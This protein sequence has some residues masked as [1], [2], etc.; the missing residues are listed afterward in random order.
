MAH[1]G[2]VTADQLIAGS[3]VLSRPAEEFDNDPSVE[4]MWAMKAMEHAEVYFNILCSVDPKFL[5][6]TPHDEQ[7]YKTFRDAFSDLKV[8]KINEDE[9][10]SPEGKMKWRPFCEQFKGLVEDYSFGTL[11]RADCEGDYSEENSILTTRI[12]FYAIELARNREGFNDGIRQ[13]YKPK[14]ATEKS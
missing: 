12:Q 3:S 10:K 13:K 5:K 1:I 9:L 8:D 4:A 6:L 14:Q 11:L 2:N 7:I